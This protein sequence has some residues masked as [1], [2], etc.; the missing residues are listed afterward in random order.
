[1][2]TAYYLLMK[3]LKE[4]LLVKRTAVFQEVIQVPRLLPFCDSAIQ[5]KSMSCSV[6]LL[7]T[8]EEEIL[9]SGRKRPHKQDITAEPGKIADCFCS[10][11]IG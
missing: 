6:R 11:L 9:G 1:M 10:Y 7:R 5:K 8:L 2:I 3:G 4:V